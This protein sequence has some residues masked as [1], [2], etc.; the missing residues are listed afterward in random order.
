M[1]AMRKIVF[2]PVIMLL[3]IIVAGCTGGSRNGSSESEDINP[4]TPTDEAD[5]PDPVTAQPEGPLVNIPS[6]PNVLI[7]ASRQTHDELATFLHTTPKSLQY[8]NPRLPDPVPSGAL[9]VIPP[10]YRSEGETLTEVSQKTA[11]SIEVLKATNLSV[12]AETIIEEGMLLAVPPLYIVP[13]N[14]LLSAA[15][16]ALGADGE[17]LLTA[18]PALLDSE[19]ILAGTVLVVPPRPVEQK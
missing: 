9:V 7:I 12:D 2:L 4:G 8:V 5:Y 10:V 18:N 3:L 6:V 16:D 13:E 19:E 14:T 15:A 11:L 1:D 17:T